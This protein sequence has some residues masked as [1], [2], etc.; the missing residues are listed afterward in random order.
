MK[1]GSEGASRGKTSGPKA[2]V[3]RST[4]SSRLLAAA[5]CSLEG[6]PPTC[7]S[8]SGTP[9]TT[10]SSVDRKKSKRSCPRR[11]L[12]SASSAKS[13]ADGLP[14]QDTI[15]PNTTVAAAVAGG[16]SGRPSRR[17]T[18]PRSAQKAPAPS[19]RGRKT[20]GPP[21]ATA[22]PTA[23][24]ETPGKT[25]PLGDLVSPERRPKIITKKAATA[26]RRQGKEESEQHATTDGDGVPLADREAAMLASLL[27][28]I[29][30]PEPETETDGQVRMIAASRFRRL[31]FTQ[32]HYKV[33]ADENASLTT[34]IELRHQKERAAAVQQ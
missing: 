4:R 20:R 7:A 33:S 13:A 21:S 15:K 6:A 32:G 31:V 10:G 9:G 23:A 19:A 34:A 17:T 8:H 11:T 24:V 5:G 2:N 14:A 22:P 12:S 29:A 1:R 18:P 28:P 27:S 30:G 16:G 3:R 26:R 25:A